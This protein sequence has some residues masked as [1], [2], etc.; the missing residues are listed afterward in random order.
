MPFF[1]WILYLLLFTL[2]G[3]HTTLYIVDGKCRRLLGDTKRSDWD[4]STLGID[5]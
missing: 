1:I 2:I 4:L 3:P 5:E